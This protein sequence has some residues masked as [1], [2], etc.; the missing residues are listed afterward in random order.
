MRLLSQGMMDRKAIRLLSKN[1][2]EQL[3][4]LVARAEAAYHVLPCRLTSEWLAVVNRAVEIDRSNLAVDAAH[5]VDDGDRAVEFNLAILKVPQGVTIAASATF[6]PETSSVL[7]DSCKGS[8]DAVVGWIGGVLRRN[9]GEVEGLRDELKG[10]IHTVIGSI[11]EV[12]H[13]G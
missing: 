9:L 1:S 4:V 11:V 13:V 6:F 8:V 3:G 10:S 2:R 12:E 7:P 5:V